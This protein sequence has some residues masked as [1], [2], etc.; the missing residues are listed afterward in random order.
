MSLVPS[1]ASG[2][3][4]DPDLDLTGEA[5]RLRVLFDGLPA[6]IGYWDSGLRN[7]IANQA[8]VEW[9]GVTPEEIKGLHISEIV[10]QK[11]YEQNLPF[12]T[13]ALA[14]EPQ[15]FE[16]TLVDVSGAVRHTQ[17]SYSPDFGPGTH[18]GGVVGLFVMITDVT[19]RVEAQRQMDEAQELAELGSWTLVQATKQLSWSPQMYR[20]MGRDPETY[21]PTHESLIPQ[22]HA[23]D[24]D[25]VVSAAQEA[26]VS[27][28][29]Y[30]ISYRLVLPSGEVREMLSRVRP[31]RSEDGRVARI[32]GV[33]QDVT[34]TN[35]LVREMER[36]NEELH[37]VNQ[38]NADVLG[39]VGHDVRTP[40]ALV[41]GHLEELTTHWSE[42]E[43]AA[44]LDRVGK[45]FAAALRLSALIDDILAMANFD[46]GTIATRPIRVEL[47]E[48]VREA[49][50]GVNGA[51]GVEVQIDGTP[52]AFVD[53][54]HLR[55]M[56][57]NLVSN[58]LRYGAPPVVVTVT[59]RE[60]WVALE[61]VD[62]GAGV[63]EDFVPELFDRFTRAST[64]A[65]ARQAGSGFGLY[66][67]GR[68]AEANGC[69][70]RY[71]PGTPSGSRFRLDLPA[72]AG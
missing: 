31:E 40:L 66:I 27:G 37:K 58:A 23:D 50:A 7:V 24:R 22:L 15:Q 59:A 2:F 53:P 10:G 38:L 29:G 70:L 4:D 71:S 21:S 14:G 26:T 65:A 60:G 30:Q 72:A 1:S 32:T 6:M 48:V 51:G 54:F 43:D 12:M 39:V 69:G 34:S 64:G 62:H 44:R 16:R 61:V 36:V 33:L 5:R 11:I 67:V 46:S 55:Q 25:R 9:F 35:V 20:L 41:L 56:I 42:G 28:E 8:Y 17:V 45:A 49:L 19:P 18:G 3:S 57:A 47:D 63:P 68:L 13:A 52:E